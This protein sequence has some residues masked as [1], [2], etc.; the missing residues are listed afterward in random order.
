MNNEKKIP[1]L[2]K[3]ATPAIFELSQQIEALTKWTEENKALLTQPGELNRK[4][5]R[6]TE[7]KARRNAPVKRRRW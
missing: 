6:S 4:E 3:F 7:A 1:W 2:V 5:R